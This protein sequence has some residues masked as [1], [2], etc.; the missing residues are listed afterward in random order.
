MKSCSSDFVKSFAVGR[1]AESFEVVVVR[2]PEVDSAYLPVVY[3]YFHFGLVLNLSYA[4][5]GL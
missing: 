2:L 5:P 4:P 1:G 3:R